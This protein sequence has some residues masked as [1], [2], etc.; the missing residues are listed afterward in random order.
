MTSIPELETTAA[1]LA[2]RVGAGLRG[3][4]PAQH[5][6]AVT[7]SRGF[8]AYAASQSHKL[9]ALADI[10]PDG[11]T[12]FNARQKE[13]REGLVAAQQK[14]QKESQSPSSDR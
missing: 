4:L 9:P 12:E 3:A 13:Y 5:T 6:T 2:R 8:T 11:A 14:E 10:R 7:S 1:M